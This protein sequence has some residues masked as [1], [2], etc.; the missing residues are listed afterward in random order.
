MVGSYKN[1]SI[2]HVLTASKV[3]DTDHTGRPISLHSIMKAILYFLDAYV[4]TFA[5]QCFLFITSQSLIPTSVAI[6]CEPMSPT[7]GPL[8]L[9]LVVGL[10]CQLEGI[11]NA[12]A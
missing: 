10:D 5:P 8:D 2:Y 12:K 11:E 7:Q 1:N 3:S 9:G 6:E 4:D